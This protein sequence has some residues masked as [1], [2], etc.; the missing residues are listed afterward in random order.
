MTPEDLNEHLEKYVEE[1]AI[2]SYAVPEHYHFVDELPKT[3]VG[4][5]DKKSLRNTHAPEESGGES[6]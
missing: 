1:G 4:K 2:T 5:L 3:S 6:E